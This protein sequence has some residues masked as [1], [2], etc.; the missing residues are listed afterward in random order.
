MSI[1][2]PIFR[3]I[4]K[5]IFRSAYGQG[6]SGDVDPLD[7]FLAA[8]WNN[9][10]IGDAWSFDKSLEVAGLKRKVADFPKSPL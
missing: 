10:N 6:G 2:R 9:E 1:F 4:Y 3:S 7:G 8:S 5:P